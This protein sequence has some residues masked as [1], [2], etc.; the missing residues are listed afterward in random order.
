MIYYPVELTGIVTRIIVSPWSKIVGVGTSDKPF[1]YSNPPYVIVSAHTPDPSMDA[2]R[3][4]LWMKHVVLVNQESILDPSIVGSYGGITHAGVADFDMSSI[5]ALSRFSHRGSF[6]YHHGGSKA[7][8]WLVYVEELQREWLAPSPA[9][10]TPTPGNDTPTG[11]STTSVPARRPIV[12][13]R[14]NVAS[15]HTTHASLG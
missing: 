11:R 5:H 6:G 8:N 2:D 14:T 15:E 12:T 4:E 9:E 13:R 1:N 7:S 3:E 10:G